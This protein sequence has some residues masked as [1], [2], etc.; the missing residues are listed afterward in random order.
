[1]DAII[2]QLQQPFQ[3]ADQAALAGLGLYSQDF[4]VKE[5]G[6]IT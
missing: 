6:A 1:L 3:G 4:A 5:I 2:A